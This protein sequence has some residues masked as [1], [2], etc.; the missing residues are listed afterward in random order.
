MQRAATLN[1]VAIDPEM[2]V[3]EKAPAKA[4]KSG[5]F[6]KKTAEAPA[7]EMANDAAER[8]PIGTIKPQA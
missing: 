7:V 1:S 4:E 5:L 6:G 2:L 3:E 8:A